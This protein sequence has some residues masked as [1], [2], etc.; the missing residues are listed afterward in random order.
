MSKK[1]RE[2]LFHEFILTSI[3][4]STD[5]VW[6]IK[7][8]WL[9]TVYVFLILIFVYLQFCTSF[10]F[11]RFYGNS[12]ETSLPLFYGPKQDHSEWCSII[13]GTLK[14]IVMYQSILKSV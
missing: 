12:D 1:C 5:C 13:L 8:L 7:I 2:L 14:L 3:W 10:P 11:I 4:V 9:K 6:M